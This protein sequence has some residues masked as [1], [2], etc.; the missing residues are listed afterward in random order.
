M[1]QVFG[2][3]VSYANGTIDWKKVADTGVKFAMIRAGFG[4]KISQKD[5]QADANFTNAA[6]AGIDMGAYWFA[7]PL[8]A[9]DA[10]EEAKL[11]LEVIQ[12]HRLT[13]PVC[14]DFEYDS[15]RYAQ[16]NGVEVTREFAT[17]MVLA[18]CDE[19]KLNGFYP[20]NYANN[21]FTK[22]YFNME[23][24]KGLDLWY[25]YYQDTLNRDDV[26]LWQYSNAGRIPGISGNVDLDY[27]YKDYPAIM[28]ENG[29]NGF[30]KPN[31]EE[32]HWAMGAYEYLKEKFGF[33]LYNMDLDRTVTMGE[34]LEVLARLNGY[35]GS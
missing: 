21:D 5:A 11:C 35:R 23:A 7:Y 10:R 13:Y 25:A 22:N 27:A 29:Y 6:A 34:L 30:D 20:A 32:P 18:F 1:S 24:L 14:F 9:A 8:S 31:P 28:R 12:P 19:L 3:D 15:I 26:S 16:E 17:E 33:F 4:N 2:I